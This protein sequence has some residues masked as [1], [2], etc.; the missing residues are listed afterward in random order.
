MRTPR[1]AARD[2]GRPL[3]SLDTCKETVVA[4]RTVFSSA[5]EFLIL[6]TKFKLFGGPRIPHSA[7]D[8]EFLLVRHAIRRRKRVAARIPRILVS[9]SEKKKQD[10]PSDRE[11]FRGHASKMRIRLA[12]GSSNRASRQSGRHDGAGKG[13]ACEV[14]PH[15]K[16]R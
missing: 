2:N 1:A 9:H 13:R 6:L 4:K 8:L 7:H 10:P 5:S 14:R 3:A 11:I 15:L 16:L 12:P